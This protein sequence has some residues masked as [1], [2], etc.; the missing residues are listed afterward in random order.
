MPNKSV[1]VIAK[2]CHYT[3]KEAGFV[4]NELLKSARKDLEAAGLKITSRNEHLIERLANVHVDNE[5]AYSRNMYRIVI[6]GNIRYGLSRGR[7]CVRI[8]ITN[9]RGKPPRIV[10]LEY[11]PFKD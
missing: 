3:V 2:K 5:V 4:W 1:Y 10:W 9:F 7:H 11:P 8:A 6:N